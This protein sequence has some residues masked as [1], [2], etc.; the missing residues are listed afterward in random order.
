MA[1]FKDSAHLIRLAGVFLLGLVLFLVIRSAMIPK[2]FGKY[3]PF[4][5]DAL[6]EISARPV[7]FAGHEVCENCH[8]DEAALKA[9]GA[10]KTVN[11]ESCH[12]PLAKH[13][14]DPGT[15]QPVLPEVAKL[16]LRCHA[17]NIA[18]PAGFPQTAADGSK[19]CDTCHKP[20]SPGLQAG[21]KK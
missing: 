19:P 13:A 16:C 14:E 6:A 1:E 5:G 8:P 12:G 21:G 3:G 4:R 9:S 20:H 17:K 10:H 2:S 7:V 18:K 11:C 15:V